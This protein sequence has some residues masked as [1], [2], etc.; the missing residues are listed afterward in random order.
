MPIH[1]LKSAFVERVRRGDV[2][3]NRRFSDG[4]G[5]QLRVTPSGAG[6]WVFRYQRDGRETFMG[7]GSLADVS[8]ADARRWAEEQRRIG[9]RTDPLLARNRQR[10]VEAAERV[11]GTRFWEVAEDLLTSIEARSRLRSKPRSSGGRC[12][13]TTRA[14]RSATSRSPTSRAPMS[15]TC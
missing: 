12:C 10:K 4:A 14:S 6:S 5:L 11:K 3:V 2:R 7:G 9:G 13:R 15:S 8:L 1:K